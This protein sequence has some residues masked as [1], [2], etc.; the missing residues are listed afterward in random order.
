[1]TVATALNWLSGLGLVAPGLDE[2]TVIGTALALHVCYAFMCRLVAH[3][4]GYGKNLWTAVGLIGGLWAVV[5]LILL[6]RRDGSAPPPI[7]PFP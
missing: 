5:V 4:N 6:P 7:R 2:P 1:M 3:N